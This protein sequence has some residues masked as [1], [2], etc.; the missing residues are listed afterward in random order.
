MLPIP[1]ATHQ[2]VGKVDRS[3]DPVLN[4]FVNTLQWTV[5]VVALAKCAIAFRLSPGKEVKI[6]GSVRKLQQLIPFNSESPAQRV[7][8]AERRASK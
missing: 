5:C 4:C 8:V 1:N 7:A 2:I 3:Q 6:V